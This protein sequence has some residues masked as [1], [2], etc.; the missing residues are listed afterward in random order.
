[1]HHVQRD[2]GFGFGE[3]VE[4]P[5]QRCS[6]CRFVLGINDQHQGLCLPRWL[7]G[8]T[9][10]GGEHVNDIGP[11]TRGSKA[12]ERPASANS[13][14]FVGKGILYGAMQLLF[15]VRACCGDAS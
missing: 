4:P 9:S 10:M 3:V 14:A 6:G 15:G 5:Q 13:G 11:L 12:G 2:L 7:T 1:M 8:V